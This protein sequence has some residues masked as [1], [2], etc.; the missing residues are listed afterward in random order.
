MSNEPNNKKEIAVPKKYNVLIDRLKNLDISKVYEKL[1]GELRLD[2]KRMNLTALVT[3]LDE[4]TDNARLAGYLMVKAKRERDKLLLKADEI[5]YPFLLKA[6]KAITQLKKDKKIDGQITIDMVDGYC[7]N[8]FEDYR[9]IKAEIIEIKRVV[10]ML[11]VFADQWSNRQSALQTVARL[12]ERQD[13]PSKVE[14]GE[15]L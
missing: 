1:E 6:R 7:A 14:L 3:A 9:T 8:N 11:K 12:M 4:C 5:M 2:E 13:G 15:R 10:S